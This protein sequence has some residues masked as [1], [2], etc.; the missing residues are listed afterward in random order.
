MST[1]DRADQVAVSMLDS[2]SGWRLEAG[3]Q[4]SKLWVLGQSSFLAIS[5]ISSNFSL[6]YLNSVR[7]LNRTCVGSTEYFNKL[8]EE[9]LSSGAF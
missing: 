1:T 7:Y 9:E 8:S 6:W 3:N 2:S 5:C 4:A